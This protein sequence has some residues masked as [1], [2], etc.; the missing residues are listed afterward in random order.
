MH[1]GWTGENFDLTC[2]ERPAK[3]FSMHQNRTESF[4]PLLVF[5]HCTVIDSKVKDSG[6]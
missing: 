6:A 2:L 4:M 5:G 3:N 1:R